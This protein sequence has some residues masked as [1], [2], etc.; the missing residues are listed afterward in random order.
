VQKERGAG[1]RGG[2][3]HR[4]RISDCITEYG[5]PGTETTKTCPTCHTTT[6]M[7]PCFI[8]ELQQHSTARHSTHQREMVGE[9]VA[10]TNRNGKVLNCAQSDIANSHA[11]T[12]TRIHAH[13][14][15]RPTQRRKARTRVPQHRCSIPR[16]SAPSSSLA[17]PTLDPQPPCPHQHQHWPALLQRLAALLPLVGRCRSVGVGLLHPRSCMHACVRAFAHD[18][19]PPDG[20]ER[21]R[22]REGVRRCRGTVAPSADALNVNLCDHACAYT[23]RKTDAACTSSSEKGPGVH[24][25]ITAPLTI[26]PE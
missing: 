2:T 7:L 8:F 26:G 16:P 19:A 25:P 10:E 24:C 13:T 1:G 21:E 14:I 11:S 23:H 17:Q 22:E 3:V 5:S 15:S 12:Y 18:V 6:G 4:A 9:R 20:R